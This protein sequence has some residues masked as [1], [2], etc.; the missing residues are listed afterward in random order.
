MF[1]QLNEEETKVT[2]RSN[3]YF[4]QEGLKT[5]SEEEATEEQKVM[6]QEYL[7]DPVKKAYTV[8]HKT[9]QPINAKYS[10]DEQATF[11]LKVQ[12]AEKVKAGDTSAFLEA[13][14]IE[15][16]T[17]EELAD[18]IIANNE[19]YK[20]LYASAEKTLRETLKNII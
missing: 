17:V 9:L 11:D 6:I 7:E 18:K 5:I 13:L 3:T 8:F 4:E 20:L 19:Q 10:S 12:E 15:G 2:C 16:E 14:V 1:Y